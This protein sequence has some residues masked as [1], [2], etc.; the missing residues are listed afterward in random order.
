M[1]NMSFTKNYQA[2]KLFKY[3]LYI[4]GG[5]DRERIT[6]T[7]DLQLASNQMEDSLI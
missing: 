4:P 5:W 7:D 1:S 2:R 3:T 6:L